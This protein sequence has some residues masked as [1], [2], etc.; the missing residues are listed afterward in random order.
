MFYHFYR[1]PR[2][3]AI[4]I[5]NSKVVTETFEFG[6]KNRIIKDEMNRMKPKRS[7]LTLRGLCQSFAYA[8]NGLRITL[9]SQQYA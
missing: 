9:L 4:S 3:L 5:S 6:R 7:K 2:P 8:F 1:L